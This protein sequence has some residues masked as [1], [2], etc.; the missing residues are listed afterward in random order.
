MEVKYPLLASSIVIS[1]V[2][3]GLPNIEHFVSDR[4]NILQLENG[5]IRLGKV[6]EE[7]INTTIEVIDKSNNSK[8]IDLSTQTKNIYNK[9]ESFIKDQVDSINNN[10]GATDESGKK[11]KLDFQTITWKTDVIVKTTTTVT[12]RSEYSNAFILTI[13]S[14]EESIPAGSK[15]ISSVLQSLQFYSKKMLDEYYLKN[16]YIK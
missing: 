15:T 3:I 5:K 16:S 7:H 6:Y 13:D 8:L 1:S 11:N 2:I 4:E 12:Y 10:G 9:A 14:S